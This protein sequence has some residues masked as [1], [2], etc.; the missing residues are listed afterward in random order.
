MPAP[1]VPQ[2]LEASRLVAILRHTPEAAALK[3]VEALLKGGV[4]CIE[5]TFNTRGVIDMLRAIG[6]RFGDE[7]LLGAGTVLDFE[8]AEQALEAGARFIVSPHT[9]VELVRT[10][11]QRGVPSIPGAFSP[12]EV[13]NAWRAGASVIKIFPAGSVGASYV[14][15]LLGP[16]NGFK[17]LPTGG[18]DLENAAGFMHAGAW[19]L[20]IGSSLVDTR[21]IE[22]GQFEEITRRAAA[23][24]RIVHSQ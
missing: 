4:C 19:G 20:G 7:V 13:L 14:K 5:V 12:S 17:L 16:F 10:M 3:T 22:V 9:D 6:S 1:A 24:S 15:D 23:F 11:A 21:L 8:A 2:Q 18:I